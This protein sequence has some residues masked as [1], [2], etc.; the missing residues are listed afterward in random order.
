MKHTT[1]YLIS[2]VLAVSVLTLSACNP[3]AGK[4]DVQFSNDDQTTDA[5][6]PYVDKFASQPVNITK[7]YKLNEEFTAKYKTF[8]PNGNGVVTVKAKSIQEIASA[9]KRTPDD[10]KKLVLVEIA[11]RGDRTNK[12]EPSTFDQVGDT[13]SPQFVIVDKAGNKSFV[14]ATYY[15]EGY[16]ADKNLFELS[17]ITTDSD[18][19]VNT[20]IV[21]QVDKNQQPDLAF[22]FINTDGKTEFYGI[23]K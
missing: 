13:P 23:T 16:T 19:W 21:F 6:T 4:K 11:V 12:G 5:I 8:D 22:R 20:A 10:G 18:Q 3:I 17:K 2:A 15:S 9:G 1:K 7:S 14:E